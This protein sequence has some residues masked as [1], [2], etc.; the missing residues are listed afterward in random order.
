[1]SELTI[2]DYSDVYRLGRADEREVIIK[3]LQS[4]LELYWDEKLIPAG[5]IRG[6]LSAM[7]RDQEQSNG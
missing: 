7:Y 2:R 5:T 4:V 1:M 6:I 3:T